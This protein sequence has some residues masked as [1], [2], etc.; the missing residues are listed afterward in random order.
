MIMT[1]SNEGLS[2]TFIQN[3]PWF[4]SFPAYGLG[5]FRL[6]WCESAADL[7]AGKVR[8]IRLLWFLHH[9]TCCLS[10]LVSLSLSTTLNHTNYAS[11]QTPCQ[12]TS[13]WCSP[14]MRA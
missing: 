11:L 1:N 7:A 10:P 13:R 3:L 8:R 5:E 6:R 2:G 4:F 12:L 9:L 14:L